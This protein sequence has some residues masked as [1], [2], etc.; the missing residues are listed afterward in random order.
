[1][2]VGHPRMPYRSFRTRINRV[3][4]PEPGDRGFDSHP[5]LIVRREP[6]FLALPGPFVVERVDG[7]MQVTRAIKFE[8][9]FPHV[10]KCDFKGDKDSL[11]WRLKVAQQELTRG[12]N[13]LIAFLFASKHGAVEVPQVAPRSLAYQGLSGKW[14]PG[15]LPIMG[16]DVSFSGGVRSATADHVLKSMDKYWKDKDGRLPTFKSLP[17]MFRD[18]EVRVDPNTGF[19]CLTLWGGRKNNTV[20]VSPRFDPRRDAGKKTIWNRIKDGVYKQGG[21]HLFKDARKNKWMLAVAWTGPVEE[22]PQ[23]LTAGI[24]LGIAITA[25]VAYLDP[26]GNL[27]PQRDTEKIPGTTIRAWNK[28]GALRKSISRT[29]RDTW[30]LREGRGRNAKLAALEQVSDKKDR[31]VSAT[32]LQ[33]AAAIVNLLV[34]RGVSSLVLEDLTGITE[35]KMDETELSKSLSNKERATA[36]KNFLHWQQGRLREKITHAAQLRGIAVTEVPPG[37]TSKTCSG[38]G[39]VWTLTDPKTVRARLGR[40][41]DVRKP[42]AV[43]FGRLTQSVFKC[44]CGTEL[45]ADYNAAINIARLGFTASQVK[46]AA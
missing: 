7:N 14:Q 3:D 5:C 42:V 37:Y 34:K 18:S 46:K 26:N 31:L 9:T 21:G 11:S 6:D 15:Q 25:V 45:N 13:R 1:M 8:V 40:Q 28:V 35:R 19:V 36:R 38:C 33:T 22:K 41:V 10:R 24:D 30:S 20:T 32:V 16:P 39:I 43:K 4:R 2:R 12:A 27:L 44:S 23:G 29:N 17:F